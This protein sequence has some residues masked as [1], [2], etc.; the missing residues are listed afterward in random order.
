M[1]FKENGIFCRKWAKMQNSRSIFSAIFAHCFRNKLANNLKPY[2]MITFRIAGARRLLFK[3]GLGR[4]FVSS[5]EVQGIYL[6]F[7]VG[8]KIRFKKLPCPPLYILSIYQ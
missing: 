8:T 1:F 6:V 2:V 3:W 4:N 7:S 5:Q